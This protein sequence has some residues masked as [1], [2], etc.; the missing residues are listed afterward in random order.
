MWICDFKE[1]ERLCPHNIALITAYKAGVALARYDE[2]L[3][4]SIMNSLEA[5]HGDDPSCLFEIAQY[6]AKKAQYEKAINYFEES[7]EKETK[8]PRYIDALLSIANIYDIMGNIKKEVEAYDRIIV[9]SKEEWG[10]SEEVELKDD[11][12]KRDE[13]LNKIK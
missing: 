12:R 11:I 9:C 6:Y 4:D 13:L 8:R 7:F 5:E 2:A 3:A 10:M 1:Y